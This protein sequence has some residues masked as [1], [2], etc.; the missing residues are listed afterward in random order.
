M[1]YLVRSS[2]KGPLF[3]GP[4]ALCSVT[5]IPV[6]R[7]IKEIQAYRQNDKPVEGM[8]M[9]E[10]QDILRRFRYKTQFRE[11]PTDKSSLFDYCA[12]LRIRGERR[13]RIVS[14]HGHVVATDGV[15]V[16]DTKV[17]DLGPVYVDDHPLV[18]WRVRDAILLCGFM[19]S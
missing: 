2:F 15:W 4:T 17:R 1:L 10:M 3:C 12:R 9:R 18:N 5:G 11:Y 16:Y 14:V 13:R 8:Y 7:I 6:E 19:L